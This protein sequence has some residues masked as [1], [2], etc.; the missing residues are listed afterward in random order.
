M[1]L[2]CITVTKVHGIETIV[3]H[4]CLDNPRTVTLI[5]PGEVTRDDITFSSAMTVPNSAKFLKL[6]AETCDPVSTVY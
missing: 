3:I 5:I 1:S 4:Y 2:I 6:T